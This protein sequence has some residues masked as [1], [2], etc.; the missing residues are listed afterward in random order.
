MIL[1]GNIH[2]LRPLEELDYYDTRSILLPVAVS[3]LDAWNVIMEGPQPVLRAAFWIRDAIS[4]QFGVRK[5]GGFSGVP[6]RSVQAGDY[7]DFF[8]VEHAGPDV[9]VLT[10]RDRH[11]DVMTCI[12]VSG[13]LSNLRDQIDL[14]HNHEDADFHKADEQRTQT[15]YVLTITSSVVTHNLFGRA[16]M[17]PVGPAHKLIVSR[18]LKRV[19]RRLEAKQ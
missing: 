18:M 10:E 3:P 11:L 4:T 17:L 2:V 5:I 12:S 7:L 15:K 13:A 16:Y 19:R 1:S 6:T 8:L 9:L 14:S